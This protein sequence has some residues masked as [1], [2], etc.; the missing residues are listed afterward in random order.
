MNYLVS[1]QSVQ[2][3]FY[4][5]VSTGVNSQ[6]ISAVTTDYLRSQLIFTSKISLAPVPCLTI[7]LDQA[8]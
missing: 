5:Q 7:N 4:G 2:L 6:G 3:G 1:F 8:L